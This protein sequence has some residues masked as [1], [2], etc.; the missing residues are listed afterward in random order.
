MNGNI[1]PSEKKANDEFSMPKKKSTK[2]KSSIAVSEA[3]EVI[4]FKIGN[5]MFNN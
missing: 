1:P 2:G 3:N 4:Y 5:R